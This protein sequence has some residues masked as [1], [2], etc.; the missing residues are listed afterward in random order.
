MKRTS[1]NGVFETN[2]SSVHTIVLKHEGPYVPELETDG[3]R[4]VTHCHDYSEYGH[5]DDAY[6]STQQE[7][8]D[9]LMSWLTVKHDYDYGGELYDTWEYGHVL[10][11]I[12]SVMPEIEVITVLDE[13]K[14]CFDHQTAPYSYNDCAVNLDSEEDIRSFIFNDNVQLKCYFD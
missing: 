8:L 6:L 1:R 10:E 13:D 2:S 7:K 14:A 3:N 12:K 4:V 9:Y 11:A 5:D